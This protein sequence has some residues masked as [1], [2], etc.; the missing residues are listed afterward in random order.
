MRSI[1]VYKSSVTSNKSFRTTIPQAVA[2]SLQLQHKSKIIWDIK[3]EDNKA[4]FV[5]VT[6][7]SK[8]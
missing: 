6:K 5:V 7:D 8:D 4:V 2:K 1:G 3:I